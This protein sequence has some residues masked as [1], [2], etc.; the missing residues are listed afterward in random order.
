MVREGPL[1]KIILE[2]ETWIMKRWSKLFENQGEVISRQVQR[3]KIRTEFAIFED[4]T[5]IFVV[6][7]ENQG[8][9]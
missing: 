3:T 4:H 6:K 2:L 5:K 1:E 7:M 8:E 9:K